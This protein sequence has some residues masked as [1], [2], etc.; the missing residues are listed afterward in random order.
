MDLAHTHKGLY[1]LEDIKPGP[2]PAQ[3]RVADPGRKS[4]LSCHDGITISGKE[5]RGRIG[6]DMRNKIVNRWNQPIRFVL[7]DLATHS[8]KTCDPE[9]LKSAI[10]VRT[11]HGFFALVHSHIM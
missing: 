5:Y 9:R 11:C 1:N 4:L 2:M 10:E 6:A 3:F 7:D 8:L